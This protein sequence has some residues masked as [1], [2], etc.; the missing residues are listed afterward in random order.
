MVGISMRSGIGLT[1]YIVCCYQRVQ[2]PHPAMGSN[3]DL[4][5]EFRVRDQLSIEVIH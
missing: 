3:W 5:A 4:D 2:H 1:T